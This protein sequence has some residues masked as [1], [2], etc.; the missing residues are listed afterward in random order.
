MACR[1]FLSI[2]MTLKP[3]HLQGAFA[4]LPPAKTAII[5][6]RIVKE[7]YTTIHRDWGSIAEWLLEHAQAAAEAA[8]A[9]QAAQVAQ[10]AQAPE[11]PQQCPPG[12]HQ[13]NLPDGLLQALLDQP[14]YATAGFRTDLVTMTRHRLESI[15]LQLY[16]AGADHELDGVKQVITERKWFANPLHRLRELDEA[17]RPFAVDDSEEADAAR[18]RWMLEGAGYFMEEEGLCGHGPCSEQEKR[19]ARRAIDLRMQGQG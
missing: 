6:R 10:V 17:R 2:T 19:E 11:S 7:V 14:E 1:H 12:A 16:R 3:L 5:L 15:A 18:F 4:D 8:Q 9:A 13:I